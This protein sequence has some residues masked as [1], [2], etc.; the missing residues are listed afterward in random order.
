MKTTAV[1][2][3]DE[4]RARKALISLVASELPHLELLGI[5]DGLESGIELVTTQRPVI[6]FLDIELGDRTGFELLE[7]LGADR[8]HVIFTT[9][10]EG[11]AVKAIR[12][13]ALDYLLKPIEPGEL[14]IAV[15]KAIGASRMPQQQNQFAALLQNLEQPK[16]PVKRLALPVAE[17]LTMVDVHDILYCQSDGHFTTVSLHDKKPVVINRNIGQLEDLLGPAE[18]VRVHH[19]HFVALRHVSRYVKGDGG[20]VIMSDGTRLEVSKRK[21]ADLMARLGRT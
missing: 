18:F 16:A 3:D 4:E 11:Y 5:A 9:A 10:H 15:G 13:S 8:P 14:V 1:I 2:V 7:A 20:E 12:F 19:S 6:L 21:K 17:G